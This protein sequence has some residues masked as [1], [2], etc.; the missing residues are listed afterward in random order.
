MA[1]IIGATVLPVAIVAIGVG[2][3]LKF[4]LMGREDEGAYWVLIGLALGVGVLSIAL[5]PVDPIGRW[6]I[7]VIYI[8]VVGWLLFNW[9]FVLALGLA[10]AG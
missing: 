1:I 7:G 3:F 2:S 5:L 8:P 9:G 4:N 6:M 10:L